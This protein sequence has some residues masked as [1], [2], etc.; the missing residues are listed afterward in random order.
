[1][2][3]V[4]GPRSLRGTQRPAHRALHRAEERFD[5]PPHAVADAF[6]PQQ[7]HLRAVHAAGLS[8]FVFHRF[9]RRRRVAR[10]IVR[11]IDRPNS[12]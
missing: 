2:A 5:L 4:N 1:M 3:S 10:R 12:N 11:L 7:G 6:E 9:D 8:G